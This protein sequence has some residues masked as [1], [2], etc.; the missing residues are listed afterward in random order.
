M[1]VRIGTQSKAIAAALTLRELRAFAEVMYTGSATAAAAQ[2]G[3]TQS[4]VSRLIGELEKTLGFELFYREKGRLVPTADAKRLLIETELVLSSLDRVSNLA[5]DLAGFSAGRI[6]IVAPPSFS[7]SVLPDIISKF[8][9]RHPNVEFAVDARSPETSISMISMRYVDCGFVKLPID[10]A[11]LET[12]TMMINGSVCVMLNDHPL[13]NEDCLTPG[14]IGTFPLI[15]LG[16]GRRWR[17]QVDEAFAQFDRRPRVAI[18]THTHGSAC[19]LAARGLG[20]AIL[21]EQL[22][23]PY[24]REPLVARPFAPDIE[25]QYAF[26]VSSISPPSRLTIAFRKVAQ[27]CLMKISRPIA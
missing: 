1:R 3:L 5:R 24:L 20:V 19:A 11:D 7:E 9:E 6:S 26:A 17:V 18:E 2:L 15:L 8:L 4:A 22:A 14:T 23:K 21:N 16:A 10:A 12:E 25:H 27:A 13:A